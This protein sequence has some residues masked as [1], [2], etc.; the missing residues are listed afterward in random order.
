MKNVKV[1][2][3]MPSS[4]KT[5]WMIQHIDELD[6]ETKVIY[7]TPFLLETERIKKSCKGR[8]FQL[9]E[10]KHGQGSKLTHLKE[11]IRQDRNIASTH[12]LFGMID[13]E[14]MDLIEANNYILVLDE[15]ME[16]IA[17]LD[18]LTDA[19]DL[20]DDE[21]KRIVKQDMKV[22]IS[23]GFVN[24][25]KHYQVSWNNEEAVLSKYQTLK[26]SIDNGQV[27]FSASSLLLQAFSPDIFRTD[28]FKE[29]YVMTYQFDF[30]I[31]SYY[32]R[33]FDIPYEKFGVI[34]QR[35]NKRVRYEFS[36][37]S[38]EEYLVYDLLKRLELKEIINICDSPILNG[39]G[40]LSL[41]YGDR[42]VR[43]SKSDYQKR[44]A[45][46]R[47][48][49]QRKATSYLKNH[50]G[51]KASTMM[52]TCFKDYRDEIKSKRFPD[53]H[54]VALN[55]RAT[56]D[57]R[58]KSGILYLVNRFINPYFPHLFRT[59]DIDFDGD[60]FAL[61]E[62]LQFIFRSQIRDD[63]PID[64]YIPSERMRNLLTR[65]LEGEF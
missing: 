5:Q 54:F 60:A 42:S 13:Q 44:G 15:V 2:D 6:W 52:W 21:R 41:Q 62:M 49:I 32:F 56:N 46:G 43:L 33:F 65:W 27:Y 7:I 34:K 8:N 48:D 38:Y 55:A 47:K 51:D 37:V 18:I 12:S 53:K 14:T 19:D 36:F 39:L 4:G 1:I 57:Y 3:S 16:V 9:P 28:I 31:Q 64:I 29:I 25:D 17:P 50:L 30:Q 11:L 40:A 58:D 63:K 20:T 22:L 61:A 35:P 59:K 45:D 10:A 24:I 26:E 23:K